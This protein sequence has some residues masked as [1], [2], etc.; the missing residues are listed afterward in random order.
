MK[1]TEMIFAKLNW[2]NIYYEKNIYKMIFFTICIVLIQNFR[3]FEPEK[4]YI[5]S[6]PGDFLDF[7]KFIQ[8]LQWR[9]AIDIHSGNFITY[10]C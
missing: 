7:I 9:K 5:F 10:L 3:R 1:S 4:S 6:D 2:E 8:G